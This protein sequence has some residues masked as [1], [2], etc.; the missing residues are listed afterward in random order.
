MIRS[1]A[2][3]A[4][5][6]TGLLGSWHRWR[7]RRALTVLSLHRV[8]SDTDP[9]W[10]GADPLYTVSTRFFEQLLAFV[11]RHYSVVSLHD[12]VA[13]SAGTARLPPCPLLITFDD[14]WADNHEHALPLLRRFGLPAVLFCAA[15]AIDQQA[16][17]FQERLVS[18]WRRG[19]IRPEMLRD[20]WVSSGAAAAELPVD[21]ASEPSI[22]ALNARLQSIEPARR[23]L[24]L[25]PLAGA[26]HEESRQMLTATELQD[27]VAGGFCIGTHGRQHEPLTRVADLPVELADARRLVSLAA[28]LPAEEV[29]TLSFPFSKQD[30]RVIEACRAVGY[31]LLFGGGLSL[32]PVLP[33]VAELIPR[34]GI[35]AGPVQDARGDLR[36]ELLAAYLFRRPVSALKPG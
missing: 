10:V 19:R 21:L 28:Q 2:L 9:R 7:N 20:L 34:V 23:L 30:A 35:T 25:E 3:S 27:L 5:Y 24:L 33:R 6:R 15:D 14:G 31:K 13:A 16:G 29:V 8:L 26:L 18:A 32:A 36:A 22:R 17:F 4:L 11:A 1:L 12:V